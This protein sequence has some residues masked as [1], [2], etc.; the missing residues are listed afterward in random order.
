MIGS[1]ISAA[2]IAY[3]PRRTHFQLICC[4]KLA[5]GLGAG[6]GPPRG[7]PPPGGRR[8]GAGGGCFGGAG[9]APS[10]AALTTSIGSR[11][12]AGVA[13]RTTGR[14]VV[15]RS[16]GGAP[17]ARCRGGPSVRTGGCPTPSAARPVRTS[18]A[19]R[20]WRPSLFTGRARA[21]ARRL[22]PPRSA[23][24]LRW[25]D[26][27]E[28]VRLD[29]VI[30]AAGAAYLHHVYGELVEAGCQQDQLLGGARRTGHGAK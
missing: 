8:G 18:L 17:A 19:D 28:H 25:R 7:P 9:G 21:T 27:A 2:T 1:T 23:R 22:S 15:S 6:G 11:R 26:G 5:L 16:S 14:T 20:S 29:Q 30:P 13:P 4:R 3:S 10:S 12:C 24:S